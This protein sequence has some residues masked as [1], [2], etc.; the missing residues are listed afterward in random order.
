MNPRLLWSPRQA[1][2]TVVVAVLLV[3][4][5]WALAVPAFRGID[6]FDHANKAAA[7]ARGQLTDAGPAVKGRLVSVP[8]DVVE[9]AE[10]ACASR[11]YTGHDRCFAVGTQADGLV[12]VN[13]SASAYNPAYY[14]VVGTLARP[15][16]GSWALGAMRAATAVLCALLLGWAAALTSRWA[17]T[18]WAFLAMGVALTPSLL[19]STSIVSPNGLEYAGAVLVWSSL[20]GLLDEDLPP[21]ASLVGFTVGA[22][23]T[24]TM[25]TTGPLWVALICSLVFLLEPTRGW[26]RRVRAA[27]LA[28]ATSAGVVA[29]VTIASVSWVR[30]AGTN[31]LGPAD[32]TMPALTVPDLLREFVLWVLQSIGAFPLRDEPASEVTYLLWL[33]VFV[34]GAVFFFLRADGRERWVQVLVTAACLLVPLALTLIGYASLGL[35]WQGR[36]G[37]PLSVGMPLLAGWV[38][39][40]RGVRVPVPVAAAVVGCLAVASAFAVV[41]VAQLETQTAPHAPLATQLPLGL[42]LVAVLAA[43]GPLL[44]LRLVVV[45]RSIRRDASVPERETVAA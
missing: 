37:L 31:T 44:L 13:S 23:L 41:R 43:L 25:H 12:T 20:W 42:A 22:A 17:R 39:S 40:R 1:F 28:W 8:R 19:Y 34:A 38:L 11:P 5:A 30:Y 10:D 7:V 16:T 15:F 9:A 36:Y 35:A 32:E 24:V 2:A 33:L 14:A 27:P 45:P 3:Q 18:G 21:R 6:E 29:L 26:V 4:L